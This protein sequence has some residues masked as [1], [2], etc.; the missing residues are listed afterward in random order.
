MS[1][2]GHIDN[3][4]KDILILGEGLTQGLDDTTLAAEAKCSINCT[5]LGKRFV[6]SLHYNGSNNFL[7]VDA[8]KK[9]QFKAKNSDNI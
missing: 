1:S 6:L 3:K 2:S 4:G 9:Y 8:T 5:Q 7:F